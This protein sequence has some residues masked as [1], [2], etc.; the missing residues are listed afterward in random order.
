[1]LVDWNQD[2][3]QAT[4]VMKNLRYDSTEYGDY[5]TDESVDRYLAEKL[6]GRE[7]MTQLNREMKGKGVLSLSETWKSPLMWSHYADGHRGLC[8]EYDTT[9]AEHPNLSRVDYR[10]TRNVKATDLIQWKIF[11]S[12][13]AQRRVHETYFFAKSSEWRYEREW[14]DIEETSG[15]GDPLFKIT[16]V[17]FG[18]RCPYPVI[19]A[20]I[21][22]LR[23]CDSIKY[24]SMTT[25]QDGF[26][27]R[28]SLIDKFEVEQS[29]VRGSGGLLFNDVFIDEDSN[30]ETP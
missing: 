25:H 1:M 6:V 15:I 22:L 21:H 16:A 27:L 12:S 19:T 26:K 3:A 7:V 9:L 28:R 20:L 17:Y 11:G 2:K 8:I 13:S 4:D 14:R 5:R 29:G 18:I 10:S 23:S 30:L 24:Y